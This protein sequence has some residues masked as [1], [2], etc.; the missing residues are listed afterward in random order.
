MGH[1]KVVNEIRTRARPCAET[2]ARAL[3]H[4][5]TISVLSYILEKYLTK[6]KPDSFNLSVSQWFI[7]KSLLFAFR[8]ISG[9]DEKDEIERAAQGRSGQRLLLGYSSFRVHNV[10]NGRENFS[11]YAHVEVEDL[12]ARMLLFCPTCSNVLT[13][14]EG[15]GP[16]RYRF[17]CQ[18]CP[19][20][21]NITKKVSTSLE[22]ILHY[23]LKSSFNHS[24][25]FL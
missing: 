7:S 11:K 21:Y 25:S 10:E 2:R 15:T 3:A 8:R 24:K 12:I 13:V 6:V 4:L 23:K 1:V 19:Y 9:R 5:L 22:G 20:V 16:S 18:T 14:E 17:A